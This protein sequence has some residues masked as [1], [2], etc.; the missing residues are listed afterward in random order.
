M[1]CLQVSFQQIFSANKLCGLLIIFPYPAVSHVFQGP[2]FS[3]CGSRVRVQGPGSGVRV[4]GPGPGFRSSLSF[5]E[6]TF[7][8]INEISLKK[9]SNSLWKHIFYY[10]MQPNFYDVI[11]AFIMNFHKVTTK[12]TGD[13]CSVYFMEMF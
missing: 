9:N 5:Y 12:I 13:R 8:F 3:G 2:G 1:V 6:C 11:F 10:E 7:F 4:Q